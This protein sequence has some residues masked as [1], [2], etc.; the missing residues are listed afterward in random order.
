MT[1]APAAISP[2]DATTECTAAREQPHSLQLRKT[3]LSN[4]DLVQPKTNQLITGREEGW[5]LG[6]LVLHS[7]YF[8]VLADQ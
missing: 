7:F 5:Q 1:K 4:K 2:H 3:G 8:S 6:P